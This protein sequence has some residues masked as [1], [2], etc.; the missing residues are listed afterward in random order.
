M[1]AGPSLVAGP[2]PQRP[3]LDGPADDC[4][5]KKEQHKTRNTLGGKRQ[6]DHRGRGDGQTVRRVCALELEPPMYSSRGG[7]LGTDLLA[8]L[9][10]GR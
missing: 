5:A 1:D 4:A 8:Q 2:R 3:M 9:R 10:E 7:V 6:S